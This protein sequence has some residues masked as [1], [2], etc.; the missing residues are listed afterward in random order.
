MEIPTVSM[1]LFSEEAVPPTEDVHQY[2]LYPTTLSKILLR[3]IRSCLY[4]ANSP[5]KRFGASHR[6][7][8]LKNRLL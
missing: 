7:S 2:A 5:I 3:Q 4:L 8:L 1:F 6:L